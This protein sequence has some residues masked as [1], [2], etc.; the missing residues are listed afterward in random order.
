MADMPIALKNASAIAISAEVIYVIGGQKMETISV[1]DEFDQ[2]VEG[3]C[4]QWRLNASIYQ[5]LICSD[6]WH[7]LSVEL[8]VPTYLMTP[9]KVSDCQ[10]LLL[11][12]LV[13][14]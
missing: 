1:V 11:G 7:I 9:V 2:E 12:G 5:Y 14:C 13:D 4:P 6:T 10:I 8:P 3:S